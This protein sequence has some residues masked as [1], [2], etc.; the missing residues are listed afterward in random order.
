MIYQILFAGYVDCLFQYEGKPMPRMGGRTIILG[1]YIGPFQD[2]FG[3]FDAPC[4]SHLFL[5]PL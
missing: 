3:S 2:I 4:I 1:L 5:Q